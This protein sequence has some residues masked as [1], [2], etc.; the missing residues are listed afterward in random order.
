M[1]YP[2]FSRKAMAFVLRHWWSWRKYYRTSVLLNFGEPLMNLVALGWG[3]GAYV[4]RIGDLSFL[5]FVAPALLAVTAMNA[6][7]F[8]T[9]F[10][11]WQRLRDQGVYAAAVSTSMTESELVAGEML[12]EALRSILYGLIF[13]SVLAAFGLARSAW[14]ALLPPVLLLNGLLFAALSISVVAIARDFDNLFYYFTLVI[15]PMFMFSGVFFPVERLPGSLQVVVRL[16]PLYHTVAVTR[17]L[18]L[19][20]PD[21]ATLGD[22][23][24]LAATAA[25]VMLLPVRLLRRAL[26]R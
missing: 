16:L 21:L 26:R 7:V 19:G 20:R 5:Q 8:D 1:N 14:V 10:G 9:T 25:L 24:W 2:R 13:L 6:V 23:A 12:W 15:T 18:L 17:D 4:T 22:V 3:L 11:G